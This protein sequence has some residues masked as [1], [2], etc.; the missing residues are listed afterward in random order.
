[1]KFTYTSTLLGFCMFA[2]AQ[3]Q[4][5]KIYENKAFPMG[6]CEPSIVVNPANPNNIVAGGILDYV[7]VS[8]DANT[9]LAT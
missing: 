8:N 9:I 3:Y 1:M 7:F 2:M 5:I 4:N 6:V